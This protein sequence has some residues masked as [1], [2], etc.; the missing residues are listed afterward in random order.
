MVTI[1][2]RAHEHYARTL[3]KYFACF[4]SFHLHSDS[5]TSAFQRNG[6]P[7]RPSES[8]KVTHLVSDRDLNSVLS[9]PKAPASAT[10]PPS[11]LWPPLTSTHTPTRE[12][13]CWGS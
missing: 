1:I 6:G 5:V 4:A 2:F 8:L 13:G 10:L 11:V 7:E 12:A 3:D 9:A